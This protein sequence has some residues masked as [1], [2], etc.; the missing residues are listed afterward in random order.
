MGSLKP[1]A[2]AGARRRPEPAQQWRDSRRRSQ[3]PRPRKIKMHGNRTLTTIQPL[4]HPSMIHK[5]LTHAG[6]SIRRARIRLR[7]GIPMEAAQTNVYHAPASCADIMPTS[8]DRF[9]YIQP[10]HLRRSAG[11]RCLLQRL[12]SALDAQRLG[13]K[14]QICETR[15]DSAPLDMRAIPKG[16]HHPVVKSLAV[17]T[18][19]KKIGADGWCTKL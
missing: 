16:P 14:G 8:R 19:I 10:T 6:S 4:W 15:R 7:G 5:S 3:D 17:K 12:E 13:N 18:C 9:E 11:R 2:V 1:A